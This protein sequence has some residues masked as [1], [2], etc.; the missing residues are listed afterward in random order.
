[1]PAVKEKSRIMKNCFKNVLGYLDFVYQRH[2]ERDLQVNR[3][4]EFLVIKETSN[5]PN[6]K[7]SHLLKIF[8]Q[9]IGEVCLLFTMHFRCSH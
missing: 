8:V 4:A 2:K 1:M 7:V 6:Y 3:Y 9:I 5:M